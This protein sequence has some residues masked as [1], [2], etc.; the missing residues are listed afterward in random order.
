MA[1]SNSLNEI[2]FHLKHLHESDQI[3]EDVISLE[4][5]YDSLLDAYQEVRELNNELEEMIHEYIQAYGAL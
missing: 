4:E 3:A 2:V 5:A 1:G